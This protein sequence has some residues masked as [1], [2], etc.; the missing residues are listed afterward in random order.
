MSQDETHELERMQDMTEERQTSRRTYM[1][2]VGA[3]VGT[4]GLGTGALGSAAAHDDCQHRDDETRDETK[5]NGAEEKEPIGEDDKPD[6]VA[7]GSE[8]SE[9]TTITESGEYVLT[10][11]IETPE[12]EGCIIIEA[13]DVTF[14]GGGNTIS[15]GNPAVF[16]FGDNVRVQNLTVADSRFGIIAI[17]VSDT[18]IADNTVTGTEIGSIQLIETTESTVTRNTVSDGESGIALSEASGNLVS[19]NTATNNGNGIT[20]QFGSND[21]EVTD[22]DASDNDGSGIFLLESDDNTISQ[23]TANNNGEFG[24]NLLDSDNNLVVENTVQGNGIADINDQGEGNT[25]E[26]NSGGPGVPVGS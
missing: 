1:A 9:C 14:D 25:F 22:N 4:A 26:G 7:N 24:I 15:N 3:M 23:N 18:C 5:N 2:R 12:G 11:D 16:I 6:N 20:L 8:I 10:G 13:D 17:G 21:N 19:E